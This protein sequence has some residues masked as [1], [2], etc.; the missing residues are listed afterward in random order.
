[1]TEQK[2]PSTDSAIQEAVENL[3]QNCVGLQ[4]GQTL[5]IVLEDGRLGYFDEA[6]EIGRAHV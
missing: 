6:V 2:Q 3:L 4:P 1:M 5:L